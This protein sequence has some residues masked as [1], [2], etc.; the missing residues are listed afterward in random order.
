VLDA[1]PDVI[2]VARALS[3]ED[4][5]ASDMELVWMNSAARD[6]LGEPGSLVTRSSTLKSW[7]GDRLDRCLMVL[8]SGRPDSGEVVSADAEGHPSGFNWRAIKVEPGL[9]LWVQRDI[10]GPLRRR[11]H[12]AAAEARLRAALA[13]SFDGHAF[14]HRDA[15]QW[16]VS[17]ANEEYNRLDADGKLTA[18][19][20]TK[21]AV[22]YDTGRRISELIP[23]AGQIF[24]VRLYPVEHEVA[25][26]VA[27]QT[28][29]FSTTAG[30]VWDVSH[31]PLTGIGNR[32]KLKQDLATVLSR[33]GAATVLCL[34]L[35]GFKQINDTLG[36]AAGDD[37]L[38]HVASRMSSALR[39]G[40]EAYR[41]GGDEFVVVAGP[42]GQAT[43]TAIAERI[44]AMIVEPICT[45]SG[46]VSVTVSIGATIGTAAEAPPAIIARADKAL[47]EAKRGQ[48]VVV[49]I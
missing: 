35:D 40:E 16:S 27:D 18:D 14:F 37:V 45:P 6:V 21:V 15:A 9:L 41:L 8:Q 10:A 44:A 24:E 32:S 2:V 30:L 1:L 36:H 12:L 34:D 17:W 20:A 13:Q 29:M 25:V 4:G 33:G 39:D 48:D 47:Y 7:A 43:A 3:D 31:D 46:S 11:Q 26:T 23:V 49:F 28:E 42:L 22:V 5:R 38:R 19:L